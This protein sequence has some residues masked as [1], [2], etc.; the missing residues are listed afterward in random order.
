MFLVVEG[1]RF[2]YFTVYLPTM[3]LNL[4]LEPHVFF[5]I[6][7]IYTVSFLHRTF[8]LRTFKDA[9]MHLQ[10]N[11]VSKFK[12]LAY[13]VTC[14]HPLQVVVLLCTLLYSTV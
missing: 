2:H 11:Y 1:M 12:C 8:K 4:V 14:V 6:G 13:I 5:Y 3:N 9:N 10:S 7:Y